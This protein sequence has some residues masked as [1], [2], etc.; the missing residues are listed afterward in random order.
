MVVRTFGGLGSAEAVRHWMRL[1]GTSVGLFYTV[2]ASSGFLGY[3]AFFSARRVHGDIFL[4][5]EVERANGSASGRGVTAALTD[6]QS[7]DSASASTST[8][9]PYTAMF[10]FSFW[11]ALFRVTF[12]CVN[13]LSCVV[14]IEPCRQ[15][16]AS[17]L[18]L[19]ASIDRLLI[20]SLPSLIGDC[21]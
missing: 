8:T 2:Y 4:N 7:P 15:S 18:G 21:Y 19:N 10:A 1:L 13:L 12:V 3:V 20:I 6:A 16:L 9:S 14:V 17:L 11:S 5:F